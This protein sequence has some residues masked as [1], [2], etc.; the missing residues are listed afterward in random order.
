MNVNKPFVEIDCQEIRD[1]MKQKF[2]E[3]EI[4]QEGDI[5]YYHFPI[6]NLIEK[7]NPDSYV[8]FG[9]SK[10]VAT[11]FDLDIDQDVSKVTLDDFNKVNK[12]L[13]ELETKINEQI[14]TNGTLYF[15]RVDDNFSLMYYEIL[16]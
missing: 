3:T 9:F 13:E 12:T 4:K 1:L 7:I 8:D 5:S 15:A 10:V 11:Y 6:V 14:P 16:K 2:Q